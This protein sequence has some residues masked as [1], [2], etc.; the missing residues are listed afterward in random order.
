MDRMARSGPMIRFMIGL[1]CIILG[2]GFV[3]GSGSFAIGTLLAA[4]GALLMLWGIA[5]N[6]QLTE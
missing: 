3:E 1:G 5:K 2:V 4:I 6:P